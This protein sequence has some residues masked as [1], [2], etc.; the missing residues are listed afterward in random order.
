MN[1]EP[2]IFRVL[3]V[4]ESSVGKTCLLLR[5]TDNKFS[6]CV[7]ST[8][9]VD[10]K[11]RILNIEGSQVK[12]QIWDSAGAEKFRSITKAY[13]RGSHGILV[14]FD[15]SHRDSFSQVQYW[16]DSIKQERGEDVEIVIVGNKCDLN[17]VVNEGDIIQLAEKNG[18]KYFKTSAKDNTNVEEVFQYLAVLM[19]QKNKLLDQDEAQKQVNINSKSDTK[20][21]GCC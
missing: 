14:V 16:I 6:E 5:Y 12:L 19:H 7:I 9:G 11:T 21:G 8:I 3:L 17:Q 2:K 1:T 15:L 13:Y 4:G 18:V 20:T 10:F